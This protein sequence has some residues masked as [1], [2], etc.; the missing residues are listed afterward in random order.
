MPNPHYE[1]LDAWQ[2]SIEV[3][4]TVYRMTREFPADEKSG[5]AA[6]LRRT[7]TAIPAKI[8]E[9]DGYEDPVKARQ[10]FTA[11]R[12]TVRELQTYLYLCRRMKF[13]GH[14]AYTSL[15]RKLRRIDRAI[16]VQEQLLTPEPPA[17]Q[18]ARPARRAT[19][20]AA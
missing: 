11:S 10:A 17:D 6:T 9:G 16:G 7:V 5:L 2:R 13:V 1:K 8:A 12:G 18:E 4:E 14:F 15:R 3:V 20:L 19:R